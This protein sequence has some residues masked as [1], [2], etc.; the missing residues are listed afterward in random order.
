MLS[1]LVYA[2]NYYVSGYVG[3][4]MPNNLNVNDANDQVLGKQ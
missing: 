3:W 4:S 1:A 2:N